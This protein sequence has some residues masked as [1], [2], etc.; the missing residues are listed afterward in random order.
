MKHNKIIDVLGTI[1]LSI[2][3]F[4]AFLPHATHTAVGL[5]DETSHLTHVITGIILVVI[6][7]GILVWNNKALNLPKKK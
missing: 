5:D 4:F 3:F 2:G 7:L 1:I 6:S